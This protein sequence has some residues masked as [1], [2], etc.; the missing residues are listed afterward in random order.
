[1]KDN[2]FNNIIVSPTFNPW[3]GCFINS[4]VYL[5]PT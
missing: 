3:S 5:L 4:L 1:L 2:I